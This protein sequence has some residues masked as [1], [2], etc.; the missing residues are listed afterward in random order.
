MLMFQGSKETCWLHTCL[1][2]LLLLAC[3]IGK[4]DHQ[5]SAPPLTTEHIDGV[6]TIDATGLIELAQSRPE[7]LI[8]DSRLRSDRRYGYIEDSSNLPDVET[9]CD[10][11]QRIAPDKQRP[12]AFYCNGPKCTRSSNAVRIAQQ[13]GYEHLYW[14]RGG[15][16]AWIQEDFPVI[17]D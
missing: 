14:Y 4:A 7:L 9:D 16:E 3:T 12:L 5:I 6:T 15:I 17:R 11:L 2:G 10:S 13:C 1:T 8:V